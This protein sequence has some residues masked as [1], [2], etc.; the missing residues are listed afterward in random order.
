VACEVLNALRFAGFG[1]GF[2][3][4]LAVGVPEADDVLAVSLAAVA[5]VA[6]G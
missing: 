1:N 3:R 6:L 4:V 2:S 5:G